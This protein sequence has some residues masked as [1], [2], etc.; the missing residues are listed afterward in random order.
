M[1]LEPLARL[2]AQVADRLVD[3]HVGAQ[4]ARSAGSSGRRRRPRRRRAARS[5][6]AA[7]ARRAARASRSRSSRGRAWIR[8]ATSS[9]GSRRIHERCSAARQREHEL[10]LVARRQA[11]GRSPRPRRA[12]AARTPRRVRRA[13][14][15]ARPRAAASCRAGTGRARA[16]ALLRRRVSSAITSPLR[17]AS[18]CPAAIGSWASARR[19]PRRSGLGSDLL[20][21]RCGRVPSS[22]ASRCCRTATRAFPLRDAPVAAARA[23][24]GP[25]AQPGRDLTELFQRTQ[26][27]P[28]DAADAPLASSPPRKNVEQPERRAARGAEQRQA[29]ASSASSTAAAR[30]HPPTTLATMACVTPACAMTERFPGASDVTYG[31]VASNQTGPT[32]ARQWT[33]R[34]R[35]RPARS[36]A[37]PI[38]ATA[39]EQAQTERERAV[40][41]DAA[42]LHDL[43]RASCRRAR[44]P[45]PS[46]LSASPSS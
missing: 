20:Y 1:R 24:R 11:R 39:Q 27:V 9:G 4:R 40:R 26:Q 25:E 41:A 46:A 31:C 33:Q 8:S 6:P 5:P 16:V 42:V 29:S 7:C 45:R 30:V 3:G 23:P 22:F 37:P 44:R 12:A 2:L 19:E 43:E 36:R 13:S 17:A 38:A 10:G 18:S 15:C 35:S 32:R 21:A 34:S 28:V 14:A